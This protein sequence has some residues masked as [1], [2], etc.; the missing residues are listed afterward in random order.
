MTTHCDNIKRVLIALVFLCMASSCGCPYYIRGGCRAPGIDNVR[1]TTI[2]RY[3]DKIRVKD[4]V[5]MVYL[6]A[7]SA[8]NEIKATINDTSHLETSIA[9]SD[10]WVDSIG[11]LH[12]TLSNKRDQLPVIVPI[13]D[14]E[15]VTESNTNQTLVRTKV[16]EKPLTWWQ[17]FRMG[18]GDIALIALAIAIIVFVLKKFI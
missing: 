17:K 4:S 14:R 2:V 18:A 16:V 12:H 6:P 11:R 5:V 15:R 10:A 9:M 13:V 8:K 1:D 7:E 3:V